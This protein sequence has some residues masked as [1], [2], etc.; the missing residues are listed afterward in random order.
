[1]PASVL[2]RLPCAR[3]PSAAFRDGP[4]RNCGLV[5]PP[6]RFEQWKGETDD[7]RRP[8]ISKPR[9]VKPR[10]EENRDSP[11]F[12]AAVRIYE[13]RAAS[14][15]L[16]GGR[17]G[18][19]VVSCDIRFARRKDLKILGTQ[20]RMLGDPSQHPGTDLLGVMKGENH[21]GPSD[22]A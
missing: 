15:E 1:M 8:A 2:S 22:P 11:Y 4:R 19:G 9:A 21:I 20:A 18:L 3:G 10:L 6:V 17:R 7:R 5:L 12:M 14:Y 13:L 16:P